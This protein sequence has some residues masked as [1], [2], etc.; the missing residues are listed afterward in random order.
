VTSP[1]IELPSIR[2]LVRRAQHRVAFALGVNESRRDET[3]LAMQQNNARRAPGYWIQLFLAMGIATLGLVLGST[4][5]VIGA[6]L[7]SPLMGPILELGMGFA[8]GSSL[9]VIRSFLRVALSVVIVVVGAALFTLALPFHEITSEIASRTAP[10]ALDLLVAI[11]CALTAAYTIVRPGA[12]STAAAAGTA[13]GIALVPPLCTIGF[14]L[15]TGSFDVAGGAALLF[16]ANL[17][18]ILVFA[19]LTFLVLGFDQVD[20]LAIEERFHD[21]DGR[22][23]RVAARAHAALR[24]L[25]GSRYGIA[26]RLVIPA[27]FLAAVY[28]PLSRALDEVTWEVRTREAIRRIVAAESPRAVQTSVVV[29]RHT[30]ALRLLL[31][32]SANDAAALEDTLG[33]RIAASAGVEPTVSV[34]TVPDSRQLAAATAAETRSSAPTSGLPLKELSTRV[35]A[36][37]AQ[38]WP[39]AAGH[40]SNWEL[41]VVPRDPPTLVV[42]HLGPALGEP[43]AALLAT[44][45][46]SRLGTAIQIRDVAIRAEPIVSRNGRTA[47]WVDSAM[48]LLSQVVPSDSVVACVRSP[49]ES[50]AGNSADRAIHKRLES[51]DAA[52]A[53]RLRVTDRGPWAIRAAVATCAAASPIPAR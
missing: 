25:F 34:V 12:D 41:V 32:G 24:D 39:A 14:G 5:V 49:T 7:V 18:A 17:S 8:V 52:R 9:L 37:L 53:G 15:G 45:L 27:I 50:G 4:A 2:D 44:L 42:R 35:E 29:E 47:V 38:A 20:A 10:T 36:A 1:P 3:V 19:V 21:F 48:A 22:T 46:S 40:M 43:G 51:S 30:I 13:I 11:F 28:L 16:V 31:V 6:M 26:M 23:D 33:A